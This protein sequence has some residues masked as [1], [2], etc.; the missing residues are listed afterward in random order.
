M[1]RILALS[2]GT[3]LGAVLLF[4]TEASTLQEHARPPQG[5]PDLDLADALRDIPGCLGVETAMA[6][7]GK[8][9]IFAWFKDREA[10][11]DWYYSDTHQGAMMQFMTG[12]LE[13]GHEPMAHVEEDC[14]PILCI[15][16]L[17]PS[18]GKDVAGMNLPISQIA[19]EL[20]TPL[21]A[22]IA[23]GGRFAPAA[24]KVPH[25]VEMPLTP[26]PAA[27]AGDS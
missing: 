11:M 8:S 20:Y 9:V 17:T 7:S 10:C 18:R 14:G 6:S 23:V 25:L 13:F 4:P 16:S 24:L 12:D 3:L 2:A 27:A 1:L 19:I 15:A 5:M 22:G 21:P 26:R